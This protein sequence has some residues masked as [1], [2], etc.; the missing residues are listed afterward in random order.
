MPRQQQS[1]RGQPSSTIPEG[2]IDKRGAVGWLVEAHQ[3][4]VR[5]PGGCSA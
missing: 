3:V 4:S 1:I 2:P 5:A